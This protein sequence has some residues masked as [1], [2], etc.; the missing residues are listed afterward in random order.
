MILP[1]KMAIV[2]T[3]CP[4]IIIMYKRLISAALFLTRATPLNDI[5]MMQQLKMLPA[6]MLSILPLLVRVR[7]QTYLSLCQTPPHPLFVSIDEQIPSI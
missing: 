5:S 1:M 2:Q 3:S 4:H 6:T 7:A